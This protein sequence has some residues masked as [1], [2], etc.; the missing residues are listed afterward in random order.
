MYINM[1]VN[2]KAMKLR[3][4]NNK[5][6]KKIEKLIPVAFDTPHIGYFLNA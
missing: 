5:I 6:K 4:K 3:R 1:C 2:R